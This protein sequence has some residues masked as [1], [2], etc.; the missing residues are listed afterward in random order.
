[1]PK[2]HNQKTKLNL[3]FFGTPQFAVFALEEMGK[4]GLSPS[5]VITAP[6]RP[7]HRGMKLTPPPVKVWAE[8]MGIPILQP[9]KLD[10]AFINRLKTIDYG[11]FIIAAYGKIIPPEVLAIPKHG[12]FNIHPSLL[13]K[14]RGA[15]PLQS[16]LLSG[17]EKTGVTIIQLDNEMDH[18]P[19]VAQK[20]VN[21]EDINAQELGEKLFRM[22]GRMLAGIV[23]K[24]ILGE[25]TA[26]Q[27]D[28]GAATYTKKI[29]RDDGH[30]ELADD[31]QTNW[32]KFRAYHPW[33]GTFFFTKDGARVKITDAAFE[34]GEFAIKKVIPEGKKETLYKGFLKE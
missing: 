10:S 30:I 34:N 25:I 5:L 27:Q 4:D 32:R 28:H 29:K 3:V 6:D 24:W 23:P 16:T 18:G 14:Y 11:L 21:I 20:E 8:K 12:A 9:E 13:P 33:P 15:S 2:I 26:T 31:P 7:A 19:I 17:D 22:G 1:M